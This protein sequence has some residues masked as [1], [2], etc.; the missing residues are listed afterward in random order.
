M[1]SYILA[2]LFIDECIIFRG[3]APFG[4]GHVLEVR[5]IVS[6]VFLDLPQPYSQVISNNI[7]D[8]IEFD[9]EQIQFQ[10]FRRV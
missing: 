8:P 2:H 5:D 9:L 10:C 3:V 7:L 1:I 6:D 4:V